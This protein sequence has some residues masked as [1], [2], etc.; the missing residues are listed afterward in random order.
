MYP[1]EFEDALNHAMLYEVG[2]FWKLTPEVE[3]GL[4]ETR[5]QRR[6]VGYVNIPEDR[7]GET[8][9]GV[10]QRANPEISI[11]DLTWEG[12]KDV[13]FRKYWLEGN[14]DQ[15][16]PRLA[17]MHF[18][19]CVNHGVN[20]ANRFLQ[21]AVGANPDGIIGPRT[22]AAIN[23][24]DPLAICATIADLRFAFYHRIVERNPSQQMFLRGWLA[25]ITEIRQY[26]LGEPS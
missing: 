20:R 5:E 1:A 3:A 8:K 21:Q 2:K 24:E 19:G 6:A 13:Y 16:S 9:F 17:I 15:L 11:R 12:A 18:D 25:R 26:V 7:G 23:Q 4:I 22:L 14:C 10:A